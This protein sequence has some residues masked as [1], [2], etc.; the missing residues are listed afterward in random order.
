MRN[1]GGLVAWGG[2]GSREIDWGCRR[3]FIEAEK[4]GDRALMAWIGDRRNCSAVM[5]AGEIRGR[6]KERRGGFG[7]L[8]QKRAWLDFFE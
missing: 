8:G 7:G 1:G 2:A 4:E 6:K 5:G 3:L